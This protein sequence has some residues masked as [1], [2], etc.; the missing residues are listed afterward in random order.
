[1]NRAGAEAS[2][3]LCP[4]S[5]RA[6]QRSHARASL[7]LLGVAVVVVPIPLSAADWRLGSGARI[8]TTYADNPR[9]HEDG[10][11]ATAGAI[12]E[13]NVDVR[14]LM[15]RS[16]FTLTPRLRSA[17][18][19]ED[20]SLD[21]NDAFV[22]TTLR[23]IGERSEW[24]AAAN[25]TR[26]TT[27]TSELG[28]TGIVQSNR[29]RENISISGGPT[30][31][32][33]ER[34]NAGLQASW[35]DI[36]YADTDFTGLVDYEYR[37]LSMFSTMSAAARSRFTLSAQGG[38]LVVPDFGTRT[39]NATLRLGWT[40]QPYPLWTT[41]LSAGPSYVDAQAGADS[42]VV[43]EADF[44]RR[45]ERWRFNVKADREL[46][47]TGRGVL[48]RRDRVLVGAQRQLSEYISG[49]IS[50]QWI[51]NQDLLPQFGVSF[52]EVDYG[53]VA[54]D[55][56]WRFAEHWRLAFAVNGAA[57]SYETRRGDAENYRTSLSIVW[58]G[59]PRSL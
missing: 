28:S 12:G 32:L 15:E 21:T 49:S 44:Q 37:T 19:R 45:S 16:E 54:L 58:T 22:D 2:V 51:R 48:T 30:F 5:W 39:R 50:A 3:G 53:S 8:A 38:E 55:V 24:N 40:Y 27:L 17:R 6:T 52:Y 36:H 41:T 46:T 56:A 14:R 43:F 26:D 57:Q 10:G 11:I 42:G 47:P 59:S 31:A 7:L 23:F 13:F 35:S 25:F 1:M 18:Y 34:V 4:L 9:M 29:R 20:K 33:T